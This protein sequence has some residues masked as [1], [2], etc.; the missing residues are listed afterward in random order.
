MLV[1]GVRSSC[2]MSRRN[3]VRIQSDREGGVRIEGSLP[4]RHISPVGLN[5][6]FRT[7]SV[8]RNGTRPG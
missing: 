4:M 5:V 6:A 1:S 8:A 3:L 2:D 7:G